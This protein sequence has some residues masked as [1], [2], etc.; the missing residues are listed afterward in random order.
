M[1]QRRFFCRNLR[2][3][4]H[5]VE[6]AITSKQVHFVA[7]DWTTRVAGSAITLE[8]ETWR[9]RG[10]SSF[11]LTFERQSLSTAWLAQRG[12]QA[13]VDTVLESPTSALSNTVST[14]AWKPRSNTWLACDSHVI[15]HLI[16]GWRAGAM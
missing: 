12:F 16:N 3:A 9:L 13:L 2:D 5:F 1:K 10:S 11:Q 6:D 4:N 8:A 15:D 14:T 7:V